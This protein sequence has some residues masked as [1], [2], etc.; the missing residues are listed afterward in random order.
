MNKIWG[1]GHFQHDKTS[2]SSVSLIKH[3]TVDNQRQK[4]NR[5]A[6]PCPAGCLSSQMPKRQY[7]QVLGDK[8]L[9]MFLAFWHQNVGTETAKFEGLKHAMILEGFVQQSKQNDQ[10]IIEN[11]QWKNK[12]HSRKGCHSTFQSFVHPTIK[13]SSLQKTVSQSIL[14]LTESNTWQMVL[15]KCNS[16]KWAQ[17]AAKQPFNAWRVPWQSSLSLEG[18]TLFERKPST[19]SLAWT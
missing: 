14:Y 11:V 10:I 1:A 17:T 7:V 13:F 6:E 19:Q 4:S 2:Q 8:T 16:S 18:S 9:C 15:Q 12:N 3:W 5:K